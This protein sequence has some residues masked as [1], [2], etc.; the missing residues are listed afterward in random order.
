MTTDSALTFLTSTTYAN[1]D[2]GSGGRRATMQMSSFLH[3]HGKLYYLNPESLY[4]NRLTDVRILDT[5]QEVPTGALRL[6]GN[7]A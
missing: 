6:T 2:D 7:R 4:G 1:S 3:L 5:H